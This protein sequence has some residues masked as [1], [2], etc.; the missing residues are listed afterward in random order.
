LLLLLVALPAAVQGGVKGDLN[1]DGAVDLGD[2]VILVRVVSGDFD[3]SSLDPEDVADVAP[4]I[5]AVSCGD[6]N[7][8]LADALLMLRALEGND[9]DTD[10][11]ATQ[12]ENAIGTSP[13]LADTD[14]DG[15]T[16]PDDPDPLV[17]SPPAVPEQLRI[18]D[19]AS[20][21]LLTWELPSG[22]VSYYV[23]HR[24]GTNGEYTF[25]VVDA[26][27]LSYVDSAVESGVVYRYWIEAVNSRGQEGEFVNCDITDPENLTLWLTGALGSIP[28]PW[29]SA[30]A[31]GSTVTLNWE[32]SPEATVTGYKI[33]SSTTAVPL[34]Q[35]GD[36]AL[37]DTVPGKT[38]TTHQL[39]GF[40]PGTHYFRVTA[41]SAT[42]E[43]GL[44][45]AKQV[46]VVVD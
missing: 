31:A 46:A 28:N 10:G 42:D 17:F 21:V 19:S 12:G 37:Q 35:T 18:F 3:P 36:L 40:S 4:I 39:P 16:D 11:L 9:V 26:A 14:A 24:Y 32:E 5:S 15:H 45:S 41:Y 43:S 44:A 2:A 20:S 13:F 22:E 27:M 1:D 29:F 8:D 25:F 38:T 30:S 6:G 34:G 7:I 33:Y 23:I